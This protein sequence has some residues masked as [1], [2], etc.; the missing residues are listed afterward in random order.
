MF[1]A[2]IHIHIKSHLT[3]IA[4]DVAAWLSGTE[5]SSAFNAFETA[6]GEELEALIACYTGTPA[7][8]IV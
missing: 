6:E 5:Y 3:S 8:N 4:S 2:I 7:Q 1:Q